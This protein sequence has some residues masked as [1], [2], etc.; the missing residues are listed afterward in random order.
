MAKVRLLITLML[1]TVSLTGCGLRQFLG[2]GG[3]DSEAE[4]D[5]QIGRA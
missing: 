5:G 4:D 2:F 1:L 3:S